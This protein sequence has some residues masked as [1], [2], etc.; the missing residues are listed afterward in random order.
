MRAFVAAV[1]ACAAIGA[2]MAR[3]SANRMTPEMQ[4]ALDAQKR[5][6]AAWAANSVIV[7]AVQSQNA[8][9]P[10][11][12][13]T[14]RKWKRLAPDDALVGSFESNPAG[15]WLAKKIAAGKGL[16]R[17]AFLS[18]ARGEKAAFVTKPTSYI[19]RGDAKFDEPM[20]GRVWEGKPEFDKSSRSYAIQLGVPVFSGG[21]PIGVLVVGISMKELRTMSR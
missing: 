3:D 19:H 1:A 18:A 4:A 15:R 20:S 14:N 13:M 5:V 8:E 12:G 9:G 16:Y 11:P 17:E 2:A 21:R 10:I 7:A 6:V